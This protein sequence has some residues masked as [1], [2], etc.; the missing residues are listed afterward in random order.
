MKVKPLIEIVKEKYPKL[1]Q[2]I[3]TTS[4]EQELTGEIRF[5]NPKYSLWFT[6]EIGQGYIVG[7]NSLHSHFDLGDEDSNLS[8]ENR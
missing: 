7:I 3:I 8:H 2:S 4:N 6:E 1:A 5:K